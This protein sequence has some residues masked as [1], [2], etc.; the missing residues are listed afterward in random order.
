MAAPRPGRSALPVPP[1]LFRLCRRIAPPP[2]VP[3]RRRP[4]SLSVGQMP[5]LPPGRDRSRAGALRGSYGPQDNHLASG[6]DRGIPPVHFRSLAQDGPQG[7]P[8]AR[9]SC[10]D[11]HGR[12]RLHGERRQAVHVGH[13]NALDRTLPRTGF[14]DRGLDRGPGQGRLLRDQR[15]RGRF[16]RPTGLSPHPGPHSGPAGGGLR[17]GRQDR[18]PAVEIR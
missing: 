4:G 1:Q 5:P 2:R 11:R 10:G 12:R 8:S 18:S 3:A 14:L 9:P 15:L 7:I 13:D 16:A 17:Q 6:R